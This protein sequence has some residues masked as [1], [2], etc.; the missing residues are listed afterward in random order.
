MPRRGNRDKNGGRWLR[1]PDH[2]LK[3]EDCE[4]ERYEWELCGLE[5]YI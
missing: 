3:E 5:D 2:S 4:N 1:E